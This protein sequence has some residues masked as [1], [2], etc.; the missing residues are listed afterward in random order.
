MVKAYIFD[1]DGTLVDNCEWHV[2]AWREFAHRHGRDI[3]RKDILDWMGATSAY[4]MERIFGREV[5]AEECAELTREKEALYREMYAPHL[6]LPDGLG[7]I[8]ADARRRGVRLAIATGGSIDN[9]DF[10]LDGLAL[11]DA[12]EVVVDASQYARGKP[13]PDCYLVAA[14]RLGVDPSECLVFEDAVGG[15]RAAKSAGM[16][17]AAVTATMPREALAAEGPDILCGS[18]VEMKSRLI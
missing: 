4:Y 8:L 11:R 1:M 2:L 17:V 5:G 16:K 13:A 18:F 14:E 10:V 6:A 9:V 7:D 3:S 15:V 12:F